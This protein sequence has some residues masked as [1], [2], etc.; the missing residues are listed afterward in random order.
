MKQRN[1]RGA[2]RE[3]GNSNGEVFPSIQHAAEAKGV[4]YYKMRM[5]AIKNRELCGVT[6]HIIGPHKLSDHWAF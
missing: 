5:A 6:W 2:S 1:P 3:V 4:S